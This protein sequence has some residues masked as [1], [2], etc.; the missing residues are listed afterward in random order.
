MVVWKNSEANDVGIKKD[1][2]LTYLLEKK[3]LG[4]S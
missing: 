3:T 1:W 4:I 2:V